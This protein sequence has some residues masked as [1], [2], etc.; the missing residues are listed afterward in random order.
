MAEHP[1]TEKNNTEDGTATEGLAKEA[2][3]EQTV[4][5]KEA[6]KLNRSQAIRR[7]IIFQFKLVLDA[8]RDVALS[9]VSL[10]FSIVDIINGQHGK[11]SYFEKLMSFGRSTERKINLFE[12]HSSGS[13]DTILTQVESVIVKEYKDKHLSK[14][15]Y[16]T[17]EK[18]IKSSS[19]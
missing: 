7:L 14:K 5:D 19:K 9:P 17:I 2:E 10:I 18:I 16:N 3:N 6:N 12:Q 11:K 8:I 15:T 1:K 13:V 4:N